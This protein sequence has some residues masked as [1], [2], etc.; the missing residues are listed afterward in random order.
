MTHREKA[1]KTSKGDWF[2]QSTGTVNGMVPTRKKVCDLFLEGEADSIREATIKAGM[3]PKYSATVRNDLICRAYLNREISRRGMLDLALQRQ[4]DALDADRE[5]VVNGRIEERPDHRV[6]LT[7]A[8]HIQ[9]LFQDNAAA[10]AEAAP[11]GSH[12]DLYLE[13]SK[14][15]PIAILRWMSENNGRI[16]DEQTQRNLLAEAESTPD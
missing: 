15:V 14:Y 1:E 5:F 13:I 2:D 6:R 3:N 16:P 4:Y 10:L 7:A 8:K 12:D 11:A 9:N